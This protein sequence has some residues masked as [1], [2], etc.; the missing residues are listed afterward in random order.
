MDD[1][2]GLQTRHR[3]P[4]AADFVPD[5]PPDPDDPSDPES[6]AA[7][8]RGS[9]TVWDR[10]DEGGIE[11]VPGYG[12]AEAGGYGQAEDEVERRPR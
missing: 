11:G 6:W 5:Y 4:H 3:L 2:L 9:A 1:V 12:P 7:Y 8:K 10:D